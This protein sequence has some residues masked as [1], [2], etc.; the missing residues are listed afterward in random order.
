MPP[1]LS[2]A[3]LCIF[4]L[5]TEKRR[6]LLLRLLLLRLVH[7]HGVQCWL[8][9]VDGARRVAQCCLLDCCWSWWWCSDIKGAVIFSRDDKDSTIPVTLS[10]QT[11]MLLLRGSAVVAGLVGLEGGYW[12][13]VK[14]KKERPWGGSVWRSRRESEGGLPSCLR[15]LLEAKAESNTDCGQRHFA[16]APLSFF[17]LDLSLVFL[18]FFSF[19]VISP[20]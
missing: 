5:S 16:P 11:L 20:S 8:L 3:F 6:L 7:A 15:A 9:D 2:F 12:T 19:L 17:L 4:P 13:M 14:E 1:L 10:N 18:C